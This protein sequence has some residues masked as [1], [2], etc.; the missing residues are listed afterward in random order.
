VNLRFGAELWSVDS[1]IIGPA[2][3]L[4]IGQHRG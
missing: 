4:G 3:S 2:K 1:G